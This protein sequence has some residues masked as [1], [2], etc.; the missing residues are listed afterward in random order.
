[1]LQF[2]QQ[3][4]DFGDSNIIFD[5]TSM[6]SGSATNPYCENGYNPGNRG[7]TQIR[8][9]YAFNADTHQPLYFRVIPG[10]IS[11]KTAFTTSVEEMKVTSS[12]NCTLLLDKGFLSMAN[13]KFLLESEIKF[14]IPLNRNTAFVPDKLKDFE[15]SRNFVSTAFLYNKRRVSYTEMSKKEYDGACRVLVFYDRERNKYLYDY[16]LARLAKKYDD[17]IPDTVIDQIDRDTKMFGVTMLMTSMDI[18]A[19]DIFYSYKA[20]WAIEEMF[21]SMKNTLSFTMDYET[22]LMTQEGWA[23]IEFLSLLMYYKINGLLTCNGL[24]KSYSVKDLL[25]HASAITQSKSSGKWLVCNMTKKHRD[26]FETLSVKID[27]I[28]S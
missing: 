26:I 7:K 23:F 4:A 6:L 22:K 15:A 27:P 18:P 25:F 13:I 19:R 5:G 10:N 11:D 14:I 16:Y 9:I 1:M 2:I 8:L 20:R 3:Y 24:V 28:C 21:D 12:A 17:D